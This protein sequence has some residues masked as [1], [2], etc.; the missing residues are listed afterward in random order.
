MYNFNRQKDNVLYR[1]K[2]NNSGKKSVLLI[3]FY[4]QKA[5][6]V[7]YLEKSLKTA[8][9]PVYIVIL[10]RF[11]SKS[12]EEITDREVSLLKEVI[13]QLKPGL[14]GFSVMT[15]LYLES[16]YK[17]N[18]M[19]KENYDI[20]IVWGG[21]YPT[22]FPEKCLEYA[23]FVIRGEGEKSLVKLAEI[24]FKYNIYG[25]NLCHDGD[26][27]DVRPKVKCTDRTIDHNDYNTGFYAELK[28]IRNLAYK[29]YDANESSIV[30]NELDYL[31]QNLDEYGYPEIDNSNKFVIDDD[32]LILEDPLLKSY[33]YELSA[34]RGCPFAC[35]YCSSINLHRLYKGKGNYVRY[36]TVNNV[37]EELKE[38]KS[39][40]KNLK[41]VHFWDE[42]FPQDKDWIDEFAIKY[43]QE[44]NLPFS[45][46]THP[47]K[48]S[49][50]SIEK[51]VQAGLYK[52]V[53][54]IQ[55][56]SPRI[57]KDI[58]HR[59]ET[60]EDIINASKI[61]SESKVPRVIYDFML[62]HP[63]E[64][65]EDMT[66][67]FELCKKLHK[68]FELQLH[69]LYFLPGTDIIDLAVKTGVVD[70]VELEKMMYAPMK[71][72]YA[73]YWGKNYNGTKDED[74]V[75]NFW[76]SMIYMT[77]FKF[78]D[79]ITDYILRK[80]KENDEIL[81]VIE[82]NFS[83]KLLINSSKMLMPIAR[84]KDY[85]SKFRLITRT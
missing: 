44:I 17:V 13:N 31:C 84:I 18:T 52:T 14:I 70:A 22:L 59:I 80:L 37:I 50:E 60:Q 19:L 15:S 71:K 68:P 38:A 2:K 58:F 25:F 33:S 85:Y 57:R 79:P 82:P 48:I 66:Q 67:T 72:Q 41:F 32:R 49:S 7:R 74:V 76:Y 63:F 10:K 26:K 5:L 43:K 28:N 78:L 81:K 62:R 20:P 55:S 40:I 29:A 27:C 21:V 69:G 11:N 1:E 75:A 61:L 3:S 4:N 56:G 16:V 45:I 34:S 24:I 73:F 35:S 77:Q 12:P 53:M 65:R 23:D 51:L 42:I 54:G 83:L 6:G 9:I 46:W 39:R 8:G 47:L 36:R 30:I 64:T